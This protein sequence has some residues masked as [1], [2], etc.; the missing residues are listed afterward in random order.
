MNT[1]DTNRPDGETHRV[2]MS[3]ATWR[4]FLKI[5]KTKFYVIWQETVPSHFLSAQTLRSDIL[6]PYTRLNRNISRYAGT[7]LWAAMLLLR[8]YYTSADNSQAMTAPSQT[9]LR[10]LNFFHPQINYILSLFT[11]TKYFHN[12]RLK[13]Y[14]S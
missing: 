5:L 4:W 7:F 12:F 1:E 2:N 13:I 6:E 8:T 9:R 10:K 3:S 11:P 14:F